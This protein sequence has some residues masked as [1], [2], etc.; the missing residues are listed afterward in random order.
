MLTSCNVFLQK[1]ECLFEVKT[2]GDLGNSFDQFYRIFSLVIVKL[3]ICCV[4]SCPR[5]MQQTVLLL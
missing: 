2:T 4:I 1:G 3:L 5:S